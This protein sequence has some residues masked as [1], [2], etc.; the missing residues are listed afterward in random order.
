MAAFR[1]RFGGTANEAFIK[2]KYRLADERRLFLL[3][4]QTCRYTPRELSWDR[5]AVQTAEVYN[6]HLFGQYACTGQPAK[7]VGGATSTS[8]VSAGLEVTEPATYSVTSRSGGFAVY[9]GLEP[10]DQIT[11]G[12]QT[13]FFLAPGIYDVLMT[14][15][16]DGWFDTV[17][18]SSE[19][20]EP[21]TLVNIPRNLSVQEN[22]QTEVSRVL[23][24]EWQPVAGAIGYGVQVEYTTT[25][26]AEVASHKMTRGNQI[27]FQVPLHTS[28]VEVRV[29]ANAADGP[30]GTI[31]HTGWSRPAILSFFRGVVAPT[32]L[33]AEELPRSDTD[34]SLQDG[35]SGLFRS[36]GWTG[37]SVD[38]AVGILPIVICLVLAG[39]I[40]VA[41]MMLTGGGAV[42]ILTG[43][44]GAVLIWA[45]LGPIFF[46][47]SVFVAYGPLM[48]V[49]LLGAL[50]SVRM[51]KI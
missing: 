32:P 20:A 49:I 36:I 28:L 24:A 13:L 12:D 48:L 25:A 26:G 8:Y 38:G 4:F 11:A 17:L 18:R 29:R 50:L 21:T 2:E 46:N 42:G 23:F 9:Q 16:A 5:Y 43:A 27:S 7:Q 1:L 33:P 34:S 41:A 6:W 51:F 47:L 31:T 15:G 44:G 40:F 3:M 10:A 30:G 22:S 45:G 37:D 19:A 14:R 35:I 39:G